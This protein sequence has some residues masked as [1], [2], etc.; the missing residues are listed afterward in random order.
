MKAA[1]YSFAFL[2]AGTLFISAANEAE[3]RPARMQ[4]VPNI[5][6][7]GCGACHISPGGGGPRNAFGTMI[8]NDFLTQAGFSG[9]VI[10]GPELAALDADGDGATNGEELG[11]P[12]GLWAI[13]DAS[14]AVDFTDPSDADSRPPEPEPTAVAASSWAQVKQLIAD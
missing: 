11:D 12:D 4:Q 1:S 2:L 14:P 8:E 5:A 13:G 10:W 6:A 7:I 3:A 9:Q